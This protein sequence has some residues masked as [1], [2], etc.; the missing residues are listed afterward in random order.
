MSTE[1]TA[2]LRTLSTTD[3]QQ[4]IPHR[5]PFLLIDKVEIHEEGKRA[6]GIKCV[7]ANEPFFQGHFPGRPVMPGVLLLEALAQTGC[8]LLMSAPDSPTRG[9]I[10]FF[11]T[12]DN[13]KFRNP[14][15]P[16]SVL[17]LNVQLQSLRSRAGKFRGEAFVDGKPAAEGDMTF[18]LMDK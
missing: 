15:F 16:G 7:S 11:M 9:K 17:R 13:A 12:I 2:P 18:A 3:I 8:A 4:V 1:N 14:V 10:A 5:Y 6:T